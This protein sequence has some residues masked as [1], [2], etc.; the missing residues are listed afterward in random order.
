MKLI[1][2]SDLKF[3]F[4][5]FEPIPKFVSIYKNLFLLNSY[6]YLHVNYF[7]KNFFF[8]IGTHSKSRIWLTESHI[9]KSPYQMNKLYM[10]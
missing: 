3:L 7:H 9:L 2:F 4:R 5:E 10:S 1:S 6:L 8:N